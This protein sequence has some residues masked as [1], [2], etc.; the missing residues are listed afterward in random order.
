MRSI[1][2]L[3]LIVIGCFANLKGH[4]LSQSPL[5]SLLRIFLQIDDSV[6]KTTIDHQVCIR[7]HVLV[8]S[9]Y[10]CSCI[11]RLPFCPQ[12]GASPPKLFLPNEPNPPAAG[13][14]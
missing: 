14:P 12:P 10:V 2:L 13:G 11:S 9:G 3:L 6:I 5:V 4:R 1:F 8:Y 7:T